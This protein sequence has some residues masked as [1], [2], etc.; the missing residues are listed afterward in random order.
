MLMIH[1]EG[2]TNTFE[3][4]FL[5]DEPSPLQ[6]R[7]IDS[8]LWEL[9][10]HIHHYAP[11]VATLARI[12]SEPF[13]KP[14]Y[15]LEDFLDHTYGTVR[16]SLFSF[17]THGFPSSHAPRSYLLPTRSGQS[18]KHQLSDYNHGSSFSHIRKRDMKIQGPQC[19]IF[20]ICRNGSYGR[21]DNVILQYSGDY[22]RHA[23]IKDVPRR[24]KDT[25]YRGTDRMSKEM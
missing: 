10:T 17:T 8:S 12:F 4:P 14:S 13:T 11:P 23:Q 2:I 18:S 16:V 15:V 20:G 22:S 19:A 7:A 5:P 3:D 25:N 6:S 1:R 24:C 21:R 9:Q